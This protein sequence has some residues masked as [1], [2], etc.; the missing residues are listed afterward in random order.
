MWILIET[1]TENGIFK[2]MEAMARDLR[3]P[4]IPSIYLT[5]L[6][7]FISCIMR[8]NDYKNKRVESIEYNTIAKRIITTK[9]FIILRKGMPL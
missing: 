9:S 6:L 5:C 1:K 4:Y 3:H 2:C 8:Y 7:I